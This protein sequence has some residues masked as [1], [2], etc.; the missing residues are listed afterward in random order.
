MAESTLTS[1][2]QVTL[3]KEIRDALS[4]QEGDRISFTLEGPRRV[5]MEPASLSVKELRGTVKTPGKRPVSIENM[6][7]AIRKRGSAS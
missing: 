4:L 5:R 7:E 2:G 6:A 3:P 1:K